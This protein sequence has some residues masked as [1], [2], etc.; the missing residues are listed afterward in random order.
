MYLKWKTIYQSGF[1]MKKS[2]MKF[3]LLLLIFPCSINCNAQNYAFLDENL[4]LP[5][6]YTNTV[7]SQNKFNRLFPV[8]KQLLPSFIQALQ[9]IKKELASNISEINAKQCQIGC[10][11]FSGIIIALASEVR[12]DYLLT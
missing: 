8:E 12:M 2:Q 4:V 10:T 3:A 5:R 1:A 9:E 6:T 7:T 11:K